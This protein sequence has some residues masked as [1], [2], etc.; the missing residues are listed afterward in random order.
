METENTTITLQVD[1]NRCID[2]SCF[3]VKS[4]EK[5]HFN[6]KNNDTVVMNKD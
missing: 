5:I 4:G 1:E 6:V 2:L 3:K